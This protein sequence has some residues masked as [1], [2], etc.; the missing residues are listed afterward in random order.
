MQPAFVYCEFILFAMKMMHLCD[1][2]ASL[3][4]YGERSLTDFSFLHAAAAFS[5]ATENAVI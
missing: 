1:P 4:V 3:H 2:F 5:G